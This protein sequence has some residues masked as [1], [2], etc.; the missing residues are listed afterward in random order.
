[1][2]YLSKLA[3]GDTFTSDGA[4]FEVVEKPFG[5]WVIVKNIETGRVTKFKGD[6]RVEPVSARMNDY[7]IKRAEED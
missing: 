2:E 4:M 6:V 7:T 1:M 3:V 5:Y